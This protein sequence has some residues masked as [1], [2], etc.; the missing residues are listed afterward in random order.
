V[1]EHAIEEARNLGTPP[2]YVATEHLLLGLLRE[3]DG[4]AVQVLTRMGLKLEDV[5]NDVLDLAQLARQ[6]EA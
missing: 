6:P 1:I 5:R 3:R 4:V 2:N